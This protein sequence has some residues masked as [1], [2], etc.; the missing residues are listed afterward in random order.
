MKYDARVK[1]AA[2]MKYGFAILPQAILHISEGRYFIS[3]K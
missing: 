2:H 3:R 1:Y